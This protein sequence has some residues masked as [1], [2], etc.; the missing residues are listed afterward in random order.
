MHMLGPKASVLI[1]AEVL[2]A[3]A[4][5]SSTTGGECQQR[6]IAVQLDQA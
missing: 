1:G 6:A 5:K 2:G 4:S 3:L